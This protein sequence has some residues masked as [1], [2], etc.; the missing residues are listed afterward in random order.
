MATIVTVHGTGATGE[1]QGSRW[2]QKGS[3]CEARLRELVQSADGELKYEPLIWDGKNSETSRRAA[4]RQLLSQ[5]TGLEKRSEPY[6]VIGHS[7]G[8]SVISFAL[9]LAARQSQTLPAMRA[10]ITVGTP[11]IAPKKKRLLYSRSDAI[12]RGVFVMSLLVIAAI[13]L[14][15]WAM[16]S[17]WVSLSVRLLIALPLAWWFSRKLGPW[18]EGDAPDWQLTGE[19]IRASVDRSFRHR[20]LQLWHPDDE[21][22][23]LLRD[24]IRVEPRIFPSNFFALPLLAAFVYGLP[25]IVLAIASNDYLAGSIARTLA[26]S[27]PANPVLISTWYANFDVAKATLVER[28]VMVILAVPALLDRLPDVATEWTGG[29]LPRAATVGSAWL[30]VAAA[31]L[32][33]VHYV[34]RGA[35]IPLS[36]L[37]NAVTVSQLRGKF[38]GADIAGE[39]LIGCDAR[40]AWSPATMAPLPP[41]LSAEVTRMSDAAAAAALGTIRTRAR[42]LMAADNIL[43]RLNRYLTWE[44]LVHTTYFNSPLFLLLLA[45]AIS[46]ADGFLATPLLSNDPHHAQLSG[47][48]AEILAPAAASAPPPIGDLKAA[49]AAPR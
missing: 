40:P 25:L 33:L 37:L 43:E 45:Y 9:Q 46:L 32:S 2:W 8:G 4:G 7:H 29:S 42:E 41:A 44:E 13:L 14:R 24:A 28:S 36:K 17:D 27:E 15:L 22:I 38:L 11:F 34:A 47:W 30:L 6:V 21:A 39:R 10:W 49:A 20:W 19:S 3:P 1:A 16:N 23:F 12:T 18:I 26:T 31:L 5:L 35:S 48:Y